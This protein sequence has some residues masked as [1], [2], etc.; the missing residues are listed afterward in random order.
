MASAPW[1]RAWSETSRAGEGSKVL[2]T[3]M[4]SAL[5]RREDHAYNDSTDVKNGKSHY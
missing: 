1:A 3:T 5:Q 4:L 2:R